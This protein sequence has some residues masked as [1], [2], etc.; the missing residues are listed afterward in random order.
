MIKIQ[1]TEKHLGIR[2]HRQVDQAKK[3]F[4]FV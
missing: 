3:K 4:E 1:F 2:V